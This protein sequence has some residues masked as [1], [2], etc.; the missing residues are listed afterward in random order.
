VCSPCPATFRVRAEPPSSS[1]KP[2]PIADKCSRVV[3]GVFRARSS[4]LYGWSRLEHPWGKYL[5]D[6]SLRISRLGFDD[7]L[8][9]LWPSAYILLISLLQSHRACRRFAEPSQVSCCILPLIDSRAEIPR[10]DAFHSHVHANPQGILQ[11]WLQCE[12]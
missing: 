9:F 1:L 4:T 12:Y 8:Q 5:H 6:V 2:A 10:H 3:M 11:V 7:I